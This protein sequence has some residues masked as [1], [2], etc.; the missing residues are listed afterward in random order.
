MNKQRF[1]D[2]LKEYPKVL[3]EWLK[4]FL[5]LIIGL[6][7]VLRLNKPRV[8][9]FGGAMLKKDDPYYDLAK[10]LAQKLV[11]N[12]I[13]IITGGGPGIMEAANCGAQESSN[14]KLKFKTLAIGIRGLKLQEKLNICAQDSISFD[15][16]FVRKWLLI[17][18]SSAFLVFPG[19]YGTLDELAE[20]LNLIDT[21]KIEHVPVILFGK[22]F[23]E[24]IMK[25][26][27]ET[28]FKHGLINREEL[29]I[30]TLTDDMEEVFCILLEHCKGG[31]KEISKQKPQGKI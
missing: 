10:N 26:I 24:P 14:K 9:F 23:W 22:S 13:S 30:F 21:Y 2:Y 18:Y 8:T 16:F 11:D 28:S 20:V 17:N 3:Y 12:N 7:K 15:S 5:F 1:K 6:W 29:K 25:W 27:T 4:I 31:T 19:G